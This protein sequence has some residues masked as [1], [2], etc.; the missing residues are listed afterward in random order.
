VIQVPIMFSPKSTL[1]PVLLAV[2]SLAIIAPE[3]N[4]QVGAW[5]S[6]WGRSS[7]VGTSRA[8]G[9]IGYRG[10]MM[11]IEIGTPAPPWHYNRVPPGSSTDAALR[12][13]ERFYHELDRMHRYQP[14]EDRYAN[15]FRD[16]YSSG[17]PFYHPYFAYRGFAAPVSPEPVFP[18]GYPDYGRQRTFS[19]PQTEPIPG[20][21]YSRQDSL[22][23]SVHA[24]ADVAD[25]LRAAA[26]RLTQSLSRMRDGKV[27]LEQL[28][29]QRIV[30]TIDR[31][32]FPGSLI[33]LLGHY[34][35][36]A[37]TP[38]LV[39]IAEARGFRDTHQLLTQ[40]VQLHSRF[41]DAEPHSHVMAV[42]SLSPS[43]Y[44]GQQHPDN[45]PI[46]L[47]PPA[48]SPGVQWLPT[49]RGE[50]ESDR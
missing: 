18:P 3:A 1:L 38:R 44:S 39:L 5:S 35:G 6:G 2:T 33:D 28:Q 40:Y 19:A 37:N 10:P 24:D 43:E 13:Q 25:L 15:D 41:P 14:R 8:V 20:L 47:E 21:A 32:D 29:P 46:G 26:N 49:P 7:A 17:D 36:V 12:Q 23:R 11:S 34:D 45:Q 4:A 27:W 31:A 16:R 22:R 48:T 9:G 30:A 42:E 50:P